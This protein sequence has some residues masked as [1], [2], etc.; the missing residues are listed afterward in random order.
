MSRFTRASSFD[1]SST[2]T[3]STKEIFNT[4]GFTPQFGELYLL[5]VSSTKGKNVYIVPFYVNRKNSSSM[6]TNMWPSNLKSPTVGNPTTAD[7]ITFAG[8]F[9][10]EQAAKYL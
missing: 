5:A 7:I 1:S 10:E 3:L 6:K 2:V 4:F 8:P 9:T